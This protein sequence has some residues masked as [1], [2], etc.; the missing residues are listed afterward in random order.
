MRR[1]LFF[2]QWRVAATLR[3]KCAT[4]HCVMMCRLGGI[5]GAFLDLSF[6][7]CCCL[8]HRRPTAPIRGWDTIHGW[9]ATT[10]PTRRLLTYFSCW[11]LAALG[12]WPCV[13]VHDNARIDGLAKHTHGQKRQTGAHKRE[14]VLHIPESEDV[15]MQ[16]ATREQPHGLADKSH[17]VPYREIE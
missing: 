10:K 5:V 13:G 16:L 1:R 8:A 12:Y 2:F 7:Y 11:R 17:A 9:C 15:V 3:N 14:D 4:N 6:L